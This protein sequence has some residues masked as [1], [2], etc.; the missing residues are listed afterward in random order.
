MLSL[1]YVRL[2]AELQRIARETKGW[3]NT[4]STALIRSA[5]SL[6][7]TLTQVMVNSTFLSSLVRSILGNYADAASHVERPQMGCA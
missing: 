4:S 1:A 2:R 6:K 3:A 5:K 7:T